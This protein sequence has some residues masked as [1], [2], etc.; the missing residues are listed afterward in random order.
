[1]D[2]YGG[3]TEDHEIDGMGGPGGPD[4]RS[5]IE[6]QIDGEVRWTSISKL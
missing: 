3:E 2:T 6:D 1:M 5:G 4:R